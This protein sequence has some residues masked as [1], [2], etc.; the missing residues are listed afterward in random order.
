VEQTISDTV[1]HAADDGAPF[2]LKSTIFRAFLRK[3]AE[4][5]EGARIRFHA[6]CAAASN[7]LPHPLIGFRGARS[8][9]AVI[10]QFS[11]RWPSS[12]VS[13]ELR[14]CDIIA[15]SGGVHRFPRN[16]LEQKF[17]AYKASKS[18]N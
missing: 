15:S 11:T 1:L 6:W 10:R 17:S 3:L 16:L 14:P 18:N 12:S 7:V 2:H 8:H 5:L 9:G 4:T 13:A